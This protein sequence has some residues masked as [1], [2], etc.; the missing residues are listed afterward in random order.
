M[1]NNHHKLQI[2]GRQG[3]TAE[4]RTVTTPSPPSTS[5]AAQEDPTW[6][7][8]L[9][10]SSVSKCWV[11]GNPLGIGDTA[12]PLAEGGANR[13]HTGSSKPSDRAGQHETEQAAP[14]QAGAGEGAPPGHSP[15]ARRGLQL[16]SSAEGD[17]VE[18]WSELGFPSGHPAPPAL[19]RTDVDT[20]HVGAGPQTR[21]GGKAE[22]NRVPEGLGAGPLSV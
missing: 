14:E 1:L 19:M 4:S 15:G 20:R 17:A 6:P 18:P 16:L 2:W 8:A 12:H 11:P 9:M 21:P 3:A 5:P 22:G 10:D 13:K 7:T